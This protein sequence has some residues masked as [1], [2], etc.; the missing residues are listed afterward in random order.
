MLLLACACDGVDEVLIAEKSSVKYFEK[1]PDQ[2]F[3]NL[4]W[5]E[6]FD[7]T[8]QKLIDAG[9]TEVSNSSG[10]QNFVNEESKI[11]FV[12]HEFKERLVNFK[13]FIK[14]DDQ[15]SNTTQF[16]DLFESNAESVSKSQTFDIY[17]FNHENA[18]FKITFYRQESFLRFEFQLEQSH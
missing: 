11:E 8:K 4:V 18:E 5:E 9:F 15:V 3:L 16:V 10:E 12:F 13:V 17:S 14:G 6:P 2:P 7:I 1:F